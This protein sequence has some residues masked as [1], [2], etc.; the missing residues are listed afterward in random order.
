MRIDVMT[1]IETLGT[2]SD[3]TIIQISAIA[4]DIITGEYKST[5]NRIVDITENKVMN[6]DGSTIQ[7][8]LNTNKDLLTHLINTGEG[9]SEKV[10]DEF[11]TWLLE[12]SLQ[13]ELYLWGNGILFDNKMIQHQF[14]SIGLKYPIHYKN[15]RDVRTIVD[16]AGTKLGITEK[17]LKDKFNDESLVAHNA[18]DDVKY[19][20]RLVSECYKELTGL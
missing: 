11:H 14:E 17:E 10:L 9:S 7:W 13:G 5:F 2:K 8:W 19:Q 18:L 15:D 4:F 20:I 16:L 6:V 12:L 3:S 1:D